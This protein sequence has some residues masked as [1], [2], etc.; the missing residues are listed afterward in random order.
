[1]STLRFIDIL[2]ENVLNE[3]DYA[4]NNYVQNK[5][6]GEKYLVVK[7]NPETQKLIKPNLSRKEIRHVMRTSQG[8]RDAHAATRARAAT[9][10][11]HIQQAKKQN[12]A[13]F[14]AVRKTKAPTD[15]GPE[16]KN[17]ALGTS[18]KTEKKLSTQMYKFGEVSAKF[19]KAV[20][21]AKKQVIKDHPDWDNDQV[22]AEA[23]RI[24]KSEGAIAPPEYNLCV[25]SIPGTNLY[26]GE[27]KGITR[28]DMPQ[29]K[30]MAKPDTPAWELAIKQG[31]DPKREDVNAEEEFLAYLKTQGVKITRG[32]KMA[33]TEMN[34]TQNQLEA[35]KVAGM[36]WSLY[37]NPETQS[38]THNLRQPLIVSKDGYVLDGHHR[39]AAIV[40]YDV[41]R[42][43]KELSEIPVIKIDM[44]IEDLVDVSNKFGD[45]FGLKRK[46]AKGSKTSDKE[47][48]AT[49]NKT[50]TSKPSP[51]KVTI[52][53]QTL[54]DKLKKTFKDIASDS[55]DAAKDIIKT[56]KSFDKNDWFDV[57]VGG[58]GGAARSVS[59]GR[60]GGGRRSSSFGG[61]RSGGAGAS[62]SF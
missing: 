37:S 16:K 23:K 21:A 54:A 41:M 19:L 3:I 33:P 46:V 18:P 10:G 35:D 9:S 29:L 47:T 51:K 36:A 11:A 20:G 24:A 27:N 25:V 44:G 57:I 38:P 22:E 8:N 15:I 59:S 53:K 43:Q 48:P 52:I 62:G 13:G 49:D 55:T 56:A 60:S 7:F 28:L 1:M 34:A 42:G 50:T 45:E 17:Q 14:T 5:N 39:W 61:G 6:S 30:T 4:R 26:C 12:P 32:E 40:T 58:L 31:K 2:L